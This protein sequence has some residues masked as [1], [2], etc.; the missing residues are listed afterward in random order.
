VSSL[1][2]YKIWLLKKAMTPLAC[3]LAADWISR[4][5]RL[6]ESHWVT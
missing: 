6:F 3:L 4:D 2:M 5:L 1:Y